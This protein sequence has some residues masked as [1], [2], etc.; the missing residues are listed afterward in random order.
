[1]IDPD[2]AQLIVEN[3]RDYAVFSLD[4]EGRITAW[5]G[6]AEHLFGYSAAEARGMDFAALFV[7][8][9]VSAGVPRKEL[10]TAMA[11]GRAEDTRWH[12]RKTGERFWANGVTRRLG[13]GPALVKVLRDETPARLAEEH[14]VLLLNELNHRIKN[15]L[16]T[17]QSIVAQTL[18]AAG[19]EV[20]TQAAL[21]ER[22]VALAEA[23]DVLVSRNWAGADLGD[24]VAQAVRP[25]QPPDGRRFEVAGPR[26]LLSPQQAVSL[27]LVLHELITNA[28][29][30]GAL[31]APEGWVSLSWNIAHDGQGRRS[32]TLLWQEQNGPAV[33]AP[34]AR[35]GFGTRLIERSF[36]QAGDG[37]TRIDFAPEGV[38]C[39]IDIPLSVDEALEILDL[40]LH[41]DGASALEL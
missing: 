35:Q 39:V 19:V 40:R 29:K 38:R 28:V 2:L 1:M 31:S 18:R 10:E 4:L 16:V 27:S 30:Y 15:T 13:D 26:V 7:A 23:H 34:G 11:H 5:S 33:V 32:M 17:V 22:L 20:A 21:A 14:R 36:G 24:L 41:G 37:R 3:A 9:D 8:S 25:H 12:L 6:G